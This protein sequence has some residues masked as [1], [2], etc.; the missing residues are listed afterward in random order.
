[1][2][3]D[4]TDVIAVFD[5]GRIWKRFY[6]F[7]RNLHPV[8]TEEKAIG[9]VTDNDG[10]PCHD[11]PVI[12]KWMHSCLIN[13][14]TGGSFRVR[15]ANLA[16]APGCLS[17][18]EEAMNLML[19]TVMHDRVPFAGRGIESA[20]ASL[21]PYLEGSDRP[22]IMVS[23]GTRCTFMNPFD[24]TPFPEDKPGREQT[25]Y[26]TVRQREVKES[27]FHLGE[28]HD[29][30]VMMLD[31]HFGVTGE[32]FKTIRIR[33][34]KIEKMQANRG[35][36]IFFRNGIPGG[37]ADRE[38]DLSHFLTYADAY[39]QMMFDLVDECLR[40]YR[41]IIAEDD[42]TEIVYVTGGFAHNDTFVRT[43]AARIPE[44]RVYASK[45]EYGTALGTAMEVY[46][47]AFDTVLPQVYLGLKAI[48]LRDE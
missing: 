31:D 4:Y 44:K 37:F 18:L 43:L 20:S 15:A 30:N 48:L 22:F 23:T 38:A 1:M 13:A 47:E 7:D 42:T 40:A 17:H 14:V 16:S 21:I 36:R 9:E 5:I 34:K 29:R 46:R 33:H 11:L 32:L 3:H 26:L 19:K 35:G 45:I 41:L 6:L 2:D 28:I 27:H 12:E 25:G 8:L 10:L 24:A 39:H